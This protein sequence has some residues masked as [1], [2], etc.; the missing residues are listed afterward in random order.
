MRYVAGGAKEEGCIFCNRLA[1]EDDVSSL[2]LHRGERAFVIMNL[3]PYNTGHVMI[4]P[5]AHVSTLDELPREANL[6]MADLRR[7][8]VRALRRALQPEGFNLGL[9]LGAVAGAGVQDHLHE[10]VVPRWQGDANF[11]P[12]IAATMVMPELI[13]VTYAKLRAEL[14]REIHGVSEVIL[15]AES[16]DGAELLLEERA[17]PRAR[18]AANEPVWQAASRTLQA[19]GVSDIELLGW[20]GSRNA[21]RAPAVLQYSGD[22]SY[23]AAGQRLPTPQAFAALLTPIDRET[24][25]A[26]ERRRTP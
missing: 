2:I 16:A 21:G 8:V 7:Q 14:E 18:A 19:L 4:V 24:V 13:P 11:M 23:A 15:L 10:H 6:E 26:W 22:M 3:F 25:A 12:I 5:N 9:N 20:A 17:L 1:A